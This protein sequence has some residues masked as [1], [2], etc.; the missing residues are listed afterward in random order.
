MAL[1]T[2]TGRLCSPSSSRVTTAP[3]EQLR[4]FPRIF[5]FSEVHLSL[6]FLLSAFIAFNIFS[7]R[8]R[9]PNP[10]R[11]SAP[12]QCQRWWRTIK[13]RFIFSI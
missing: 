4:P 5:F 11:D 3:L 9:N 13:H 12:R 6:P 7:R 2:Y 8:L 10:V 1:G